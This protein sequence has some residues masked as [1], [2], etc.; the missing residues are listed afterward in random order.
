MTATRQFSTKRARGSRLAEPPQGPLGP[1]RFLGKTTGVAALFS[2]R[3]GVGI[4]LRIGGRRP[5]RNV[6]RFQKLLGRQ[7]GTAGPARRV[8][9]LPVGADDDGAASQL[10][11]Q[12][13]DFVV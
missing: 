1:S 10:A 9:D 2:R 5:F 6:E 12:P 8:L 3:P 11:R 13:H 7:N 4:I